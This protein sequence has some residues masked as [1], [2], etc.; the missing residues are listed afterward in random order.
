M[1]NEFGIKGHNL[2]EGAF[3][4]YEITLNGHYAGLVQKPEGMFT[5]S[6]FTDKIVSK[7]HT[8]E[9]EAIDAMKEYL[10]KRK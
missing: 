3:R 5:W 1:A 10:L 6:C 4:L 8:T 2:I 7:G 9:R